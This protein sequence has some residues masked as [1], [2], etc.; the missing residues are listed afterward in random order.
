MPPIQKSG[1]HHGI[2]WKLY[3][4]QES[5]LTP[6]RFPPTQKGSGSPWWTLN[7]K[8]EKYTPSNTLPPAPAGYEGA[9][10]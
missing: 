1:E 3:V 9:P 5:I 6:T 2:G 8:T 4:D 7:I 10:L